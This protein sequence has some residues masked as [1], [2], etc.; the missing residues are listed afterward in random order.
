[1]S[2]P[3]PRTELVYGVD[4]KSKKSLKIGT[5]T[6]FRP[7]QWNGN[8]FQKWLITTLEQYGGISKNSDL[9]SALTGS[10]LAMALWKRSVTSPLIDESNNY[11]YAE[12]F[13]DTALQM[14]ASDFLAAPETKQST[15]VYHEL[16][17]TM[18]TNAV[19]AIISKK[20]GLITFYQ[21]DQIN[22][23]IAGDLFEAFIGTIYIVLKVLPNTYKST[24]AMFSTQLTFNIIKSI[25]PKFF[26]INYTKHYYQSPTS[27]LDEIVFASNKGDYYTDK[28]KV[29]N[30]G[31]V[32]GKILDQFVKIAGPNTA[33]TQEERKSIGAITTLLKLKQY[34]ENARYWLD[35]HGITDLTNLS[36]VALLHRTFEEVDNGE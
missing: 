20:I 11:D 35:I 9:M 4:K 28:F 25:Y 8:I 29:N 19:L 26:N 2:L 27:F 1:M 23:K 12:K 10:N 15:A 22:E 32:I 7:N 36:E 30:D 3:I 16:S 18:T 34:D 33:T 13:G 14:A 21:G 17:K 6:E 31:S 5:G 24:Y